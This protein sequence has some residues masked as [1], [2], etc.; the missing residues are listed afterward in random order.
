MRHSVSNSSVSS[1]S[2]SSQGS[3]TGIRVI[4]L[5][6]VISGPFCTQILGDHGADV[7]KVEPPGRGDIVRSQGNM[8]R[9]FS[10]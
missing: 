7:I 3:L 8:V 9:G 5:T 4:D 10:W 6:R 1:T 2:N